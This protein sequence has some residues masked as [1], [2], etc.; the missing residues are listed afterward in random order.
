MTETKTVPSME[1]LERLGL[2]AALKTVARQREYATPQLRR[3]LRT[4]FEHFR[5]VTPEKLKDFREKLKKRTQVSWVS[6]DFYGERTRHWTWY[7]LKMVPLE[8]YT[9]VPPPDVLKALSDAKEL[10]CFDGFVVATAEIQTRAEKL[11]SRLPDPILF[12][13][14][15]DCQNLYF[16][17]QWDD[18][19]KIED[20]LAEGE[21]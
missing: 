5:V 9:M 1:E 4:A 14:I 3:K 13:V 19:V 21:G 7:G 18:D 17:A 10:D 11:P 16:I 2:T 15:T 20:I 8:H 12:G 6:R